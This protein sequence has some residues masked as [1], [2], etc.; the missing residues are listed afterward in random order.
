MPG[1]NWLG[2]H[3]LIMSFL[4]EGMYCVDP[5]IEI[6]RQAIREQRCLEF[7]YRSL[8]RVVEPMRLGLGTHG[9]WQLRAQQTGGRSSSGRVGDGTP[10]LFEV[11]DIRSLALLTTVFDI[12][13]L[14]AR[15]DQAFTCIDIE[16]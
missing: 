5:S 1:Q 10:K 13:A 7:R 2:I 9:S 6:I 11:A 4:R 16:L 8:P 15:G 14:Y 3:V 12:P